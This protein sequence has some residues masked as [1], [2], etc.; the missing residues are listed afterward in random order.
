VLD[1]FL[2]LDRDITR[3]L[4]KEAA[5]E[6]RGGE[7][8]V[9]RAVLEQLRASLTHLLRNALDHGLEPAEA[10]TVAGKPARGSVTI[11]VAQR[12]G[13]LQVE[14]ADDDSAV[15][16]TLEKGILEAA[17]YQVRVAPTAP[18]PWSCSSASPATWSSP[19]SRC[20]GWTGAR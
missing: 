17:G 7:V 2:R 12:E 3:E 6:L 8:E 14:V 19:T 18:P 10:R 15:T 4:G 9:D 5:L 20:P 1:G 16:R 13:V 11:V